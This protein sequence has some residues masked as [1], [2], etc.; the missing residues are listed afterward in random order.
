MTIH[1]KHLKPMFHIDFHGKFDR[2]QQSVRGDIDCGSTSMEKYF[3]KEDQEVMVEPIYTAF[4]K[5]I[6]K[7][8]KGMKIGSDGLRGRVE[9][10]PELQGWFAW[11]IHSMSS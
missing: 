3:K 10:D 1:P 5:K 11:D 7:V 2:K 8:Y 4:R 9:I 6:N